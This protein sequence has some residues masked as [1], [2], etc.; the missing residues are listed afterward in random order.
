MFIESLIALLWRVAQALVVNTNTN[1]VAIAMS[2]DSRHQPRPSGFLGSS[3]FPAFDPLPDPADDEGGGGGDVGAPAFPSFSFSA[4]DC[5]ILASDATNS[6]A[7]NPDLSLSTRT[8]SSTFS[9]KSKKRK[10]DKAI[11]SKRIDREKPTTE[12]VPSFTF[13][14]KSPPDNLFSFDRRGDNNN[15]LLGAN[16]EKVPRYISFGKAYDLNKRK[17]DANKHDSSTEVHEFIPLSASIGASSDRYEED[18]LNI[19]QNIQESP[20]FVAKSTHLHTRL[21]NNPKNLST[22]LELLELQDTLIPSPTASMDPSASL[23]KSGLEKT[24][25]DRK[26]AIYEKAVKHFPTNFQLVGAYLGLCEETWADGAKIL[27]AWEKALKRTAPDSG[28]NSRD[29]IGLWDKYLTFRQSHYP[30]FNVNSC[31]DAFET[32]MNA[33]SEFED[34][35]YE[36]QSALLHF[37][38]RLCNFLLAAGY[39]ERAVAL[40]QAMIEFSCFTPPAF[41]AEMMS[42]FQRMELFEEFWESECA[43]IGEAG[44]KGWVNNVV[45]AISFERSR[46]NSKKDDDLELGDLYGKWF[47]RETEAM[48]SDWAPQ[49]SAWSDESS[50]NQ[51]VDPFATIIFDDV[52]PFLFSLTHESLKMQLLSN[53]LNLLGLPFNNT[54]SSAAS[55]LFGSSAPL[56]N[57]QAMSN[58]F[59]SQFFKGTKTEESTFPA[60]LFPLTLSSLFPTT[61]VAIS[62]SFNANQVAETSQTAYGRL[63]FLKNILLQC[64]NSPSSGPLVDDDLLFPTILAIESANDGIKASLKTGKLLLKTERMNL[65]LWSAYSM[66]EVRRGKIEEAFKILQTAISSFRSFP[67]ENQRGAVFLF[68]TYAELQINAQQYVKALLT[69]VA[70]ADP[71]ADLP[72]LHSSADE[73]PSSIRLLK[74]RK[75]L[76]DQCDSAINSCKQSVTPAVIRRTSAWITVFATYVY[77][78]ADNVHES[79]EFLSQTLGTAGLPRALKELVHDT[80]CRMYIRHASRPGYFVRPADLRAVVESAVF[81]FPSNT[82]FLQLFAQTEERAKIDNRVRRAIDSVLKRQVNTFTRLL[83]N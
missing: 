66:L 51:D 52:R 4:T 13:A 42:F 30:S 32:A 49:R 75:F 43:R 24:I 15:T 2:G 82:V 74:A 76:S 46:T 71:S 78:I 36:I 26:L 62:Q 10:K 22:W 56:M 58:A 81:E 27:T 12:T 50:D 7:L 6:A 35:S 59:V 48:Y 77:L 53:F 63:P 41:S 45:G 40:F 5:D 64:K 67:L 57:C 9:S 60:T 70:F 19:R 68:L 47:Q 80:R 31:V 34:D 37:F 69:L 61:F 44:A 72:S 8:H 65:V 33:I 54:E 11:E 73:M 21:E 23:R 1:I 16:L 14:K 17:M 28:G 3:L 83:K 79:L 39:T 18:D 29:A 55:D 20:E 38:T 25:K